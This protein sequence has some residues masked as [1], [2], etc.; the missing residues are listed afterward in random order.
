MNESPF[1][2]LRVLPSQGEAEAIGQLLKEAGVDYRIDTG[3]PGWNSAK[4]GVV[5]ANSRMLMIPVEQF[6]E[7]NSLLELSAA[8][9]EVLIDDE[10]YLNDFTDEELT[11]IVAQRHEWSTHDYLAAIKLLDQ[12][13][14]QIDPEMIARQ[15]EEN[16]R[17]IREP[18]SA[19]KA[20]LSRVAIVALFGGPMGLLQGYHY[21]QSTKT[22][23][24]GEKYFEYD[25][26]TRSKGQ[27][28]FSAGIVS[29]VAWTVIILLLRQ[30]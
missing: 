18:K 4:A 5:D 24:T 10:H 2:L 6:G 11:Q 8:Q 9:Q 7:A 26:A 13:G 19:H 16:L 21:W 30:R 25:A 29:T 12:R 28:I 23:P 20:T 1:E 14:I 22:D 27:F 15:Q 17:Q 3:A